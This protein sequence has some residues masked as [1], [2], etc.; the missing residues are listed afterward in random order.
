ME[1]E[2][3]YKRL[4]SEINHAFPDSSVCLSVVG[5]NV[6]VSGQA[7][8]I[9]EA[10]HIIRIVQFNPDRYS[11]AA[12]TGGLT[13]E[14]E[15]TNPP[16]DAAAAD[17]PAAPPAE[18]EATVT[19]A[20]TLIGLG[21]TTTQATQ[22]RQ[23]ADNRQAGQ[24]GLSVVNLLRVPGE[25]QVNLKVVVAE[26]NRSALRSIGIN[27]SIFNNQGMLTFAQLT[28]QIASSQVGGA[29]TTI[30]TTASSA[31]NNLPTVLDG[32]QI[33]MAIN[34]LRDLSYA[35]SLAEPNLT[36]MNGQTAAFQAGGAFPVPVVTGFTAS[37]LQGVQYVPYGIQLSFTP[38]VTDKD[39]VRLNVQAQVS[40]RD[41]TR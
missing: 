36:T 2:R 13:R 39:R 24:R 27:F 17:Q 9:A 25:Q 32:G 30:G 18:N 1:R 41:L 10:A 31:A 15:A 6:V 8:D 11:N 35:R 21:G 3:H 26:V 40:T 19:N 23:T 28:G 37:G 22:T 4:E 12:R 20:T 16:P 29:S 38:F 33:I 14:T 34:A 7:K 5:Q